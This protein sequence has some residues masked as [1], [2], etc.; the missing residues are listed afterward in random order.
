MSA[1]ADLPSLYR[2]HQAISYQGNCASGFF[3]RERKMMGNEV[4]EHFVTFYSPG[5]FFSEQSTDPIE[6][7]DIDVATL[8]ARKI[9]ER[10]GV[11]PYAFQFIT[12]GRNSADLDSKVIARSPRYFLGGKIETLGEIEARND[13][14]E[15]VLIEN[16]RSNNCPR[17]VVNNNSY[18][19]TQ[20]MNDDDVIV[21]FQP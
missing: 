20:M 2:E 13:P 8:M 19:S 3:L 21:D 11:T 17:V 4:Q 1:K 9:V 16:M 7:W 10:D 5:T 14:S 15:C 6:S 18:K 12:R